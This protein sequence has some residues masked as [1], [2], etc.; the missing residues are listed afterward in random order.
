MNKQKNLFLRTFSYSSIIIFIS[1]IWYFANIPI[2]SNYLHDIELKTYDLLFV[3]RHGLRMDPKPP[4]NIIIVG[5]DAGSINKVGVSWPWP[6][7][8]HAS[9]VDALVQAKAKL[10]IFD[11]IFDTISP[12][13]T[14]TE[15]ILGSQTIAKT[16]FDAG[17][18]DDSIF[19][20]SI[21]SAMNVLLA[22]EAEPL[23]KSQYQAVL[24]INTYLNAINKDIRYLGNSSVTYDND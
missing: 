1:L 16:S 7:Q 17:K 4:Q 8:F 21:K 13:S 5:I 24:P 2:I 10:I 23:S 3:T 20:Q 12:L 6:R 9:L 18:E 22:C 19:A 14:Q 11:I 15:D